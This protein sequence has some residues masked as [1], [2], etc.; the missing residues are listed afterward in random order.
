[1]I[2]VVLTLIAALLFGLSSVIGQRSTKQVPQRG[3][4]H[5]V[6][7]PEPGPAG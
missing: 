4:T 7:E 2:A 1:M 3:A 5:G 6:N